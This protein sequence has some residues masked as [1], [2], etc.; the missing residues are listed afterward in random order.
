MPLKFNIKD[1]TSSIHNSF[2]KVRSQRRRNFSLTYLRQQRKSRSQN[3]RCQSRIIV[4]SK[5]HNLSVSFFFL[6]IHILVHRRQGKTETLKF[7]SGL[8]EVLRQRSRCFN[9]IIIVEVS[10]RDFLISLS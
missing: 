4:R 5:V 6:L 7:V 3:L 9:F 1:K 8:E 2:R 10:E